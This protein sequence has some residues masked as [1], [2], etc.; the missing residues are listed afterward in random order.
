MNDGPL[1]QSVWQKQ[2]ICKPRRNGSNFGECHIKQGKLRFCVQTECCIK[3]RDKNE[4]FIQVFK[5]GLGLK[6]D[7]FNKLFSSKLLRLFINPQDS[8]I[9]TIHFNHISKYFS[10][11]QNKNCL[12]IQ[13]LYIKK[14]FKRNHKISF[15]FL[16]M[17]QI[18]NCFQPLYIS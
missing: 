7:L 8:Q 14:T 18:H 3:E 16:P 6:E 12:Q 11:R 15:L 10:K 2:E 17:C 1:L 4:Y 9:S 5:N 13:I